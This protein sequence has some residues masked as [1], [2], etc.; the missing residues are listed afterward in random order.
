MSTQ[1][2]VVGT[3]IIVLAGRWAN[4]KPIDVSAAIGIGVYALGIAALSATNEKLAT[5]FATLVLVG[6]GFIYIIPLADKLGLLDTAK[7]GKVT[8]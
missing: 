1:A 2:Q 7:S 6:A 8:R 4:D 5:Q 3:G